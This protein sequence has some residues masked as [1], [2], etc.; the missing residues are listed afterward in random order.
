MDSSLS[1]EK[2]LV[3]TGSVDSDLEEQLVNI[4]IAK[5]KKRDIMTNPEKIKQKL[6]ESKHLHEEIT[7]EQ[8]SIDLPTI[9][10]RQ[11]PTI[12]IINADTTPFRINP[13]STTDNPQ[14]LPSFKIQRPHPQPLDILTTNK[15]SSIET[16]IPSQTLARTSSLDT[17]FKYTNHPFHDSQDVELAKRWERQR[18]L[19]SP[20]RQ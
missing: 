17:H 14:P 3:R 13:I 4:G 9:L 2:R 19:Q 5:K 20:T 6:N 8:D 15:Y 12:Q 16:D 18:K 1:L 7:S 11:V 10:P